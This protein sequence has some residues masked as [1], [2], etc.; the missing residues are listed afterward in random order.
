MSKYMES[1]HHITES[2]IGLIDLYLHRDDLEGAK[3]MMKEC[4]DQL[5]ELMATRLAE[6]S[7]NLPEWMVPT[8]FVVNDNPL[9][10]DK[11]ARIKRV[12][13]ATRYGLKETKDALEKFEWNEDLATAYLMYKGVGVL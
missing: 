5:S 10:S 1:H 6:M 4:K 13:E 7:G 12:R 8:P 9:V 2:Y 3:R 11:V